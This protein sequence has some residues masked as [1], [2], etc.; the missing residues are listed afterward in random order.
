ML[1]GRG[2]DGLK[3][4]F[5][6]ILFHLTVNQMIPIRCKTVLLTGQHFIDLLPSMEPFTDGLIF[7]CSTSHVIFT[8]YYQSKKTWSHPDSQTLRTWVEG[9]FIDQNNQ[10]KW[11]CITNTYRLVSLGKSVLFDPRT[12]LL[13]PVCGLGQQIRPRVKENCCCPQIWSI[14]VYYWPVD[15]TSA[16]FIRWHHDHD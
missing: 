9:V 7:I 2:G 11:R 4:I 12:D 15:R 3:I 16:I 5:L 6:F 13:P 10:K 1:W 8:S 14:T